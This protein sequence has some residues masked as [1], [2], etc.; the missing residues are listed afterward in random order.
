MRLRGHPLLFGAALFIAIVTLLC[1]VLPGLLGLDPYR[2]DPSALYASPSLEHPLGTDAAGR[3]FLA[4]LLYGGR[5]SLAVAV[6]TG[7]VVVA[8]GTTLGMLAGYYGG[9]VDAAVM[10]LVEATRAIP[11]LPLM[12]L[13]AAVDPAR[14]VP[15]GR[16]VVSVLSVALVLGLFGW[17]AAARHVRAAAL[18]ARNLDYVVAARALGLPEL[19][20]LTRHVLPEASSPLIVA[21]T[22]SLGDFILYESV[23]SFLGLG[24]QPP[25]PSWG[26]MLSR[27][28]VDL[29]LAPRLILLPG[30]LT[31]ALVA[32]F[33]LL[34][35]GLREAL[36]P[37]S[38]W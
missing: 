16:E 35:D 22:L 23:L 27:G 7:V 15:G 37:R 29:A 24:V 38:V 19:R 36:D 14:F 32:A 3:D 8:I 28:L 1:F 17:T 2:I 5:I 4:R 20:I 11:K 6:L 18:R 10:R 12:L 30:L 31:F 33:Q 21:T 13:F 34:G 9:V 26:A 25:V